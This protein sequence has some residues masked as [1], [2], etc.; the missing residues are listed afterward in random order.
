MPTK[1]YYTIKSGNNN[2]D[3]PD[4]KLVFFRKPTEYRFTFKFSSNCLYFLNDS[5]YDLDLNKLAGISRNLSPV[6]CGSRFSWNCGGKTME[7]LSA[8]PWIQLRAY[9]EENNKRVPTSNSPLERIGSVRPE[10]YYDGIIRFRSMNQSE[11]DKYKTLSVSSGDPITASSQKSIYD[12]GYR[13]VSEFRLW[14]SSDR[15]LNPDYDKMI[16]PDNI[17][18]YIKGQMIAVMP[19]KAPSSMGYYYYYPWFGG[20]YPMGCP[21][22][23]DIEIIHDY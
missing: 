21:H 22:D 17:S 5:R 10:I 20:D 11:I 12:S 7:E 16:L 13:Y 15:S 2:C 19:I 8:D 18:N 3:P 1:R 9:V 4:S 14:I 23:M 6:Q